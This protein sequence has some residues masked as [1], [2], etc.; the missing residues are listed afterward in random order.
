MHTYMNQAELY[1]LVSRLGVVRMYS[2]MTN[3]VIND[4]QGMMSAEDELLYLFANGK[5]NDLGLS[6]Y[7]YVISSSTREG[8]YLKRVFTAKSNASKCAKVE[9]AY[10]NFLPI[11][12]IYYDK[13]GNVITKTYLSN[14][15]MTGNFTFPKRV[16]EVTYF[17]EKGDSTVRLDLYSN[18][19]VNQPDPMFDFEIPSDA[20]VLDMKDLTK[21]LKKAASEKSSK[22]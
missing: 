6:E 16:T 20:K 19:R 5:G 4:V 14:Y 8:E 10:K 17:M 13:K 12:A 18:I 1:F 11:C 3:E 7:E 22:K 9:I 2:P 15:E 21:E